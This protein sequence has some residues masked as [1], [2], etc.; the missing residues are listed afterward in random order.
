MPRKLVW[1]DRKYM[2]GWGCSECAWV[3]NPS[4]AP[5]GKSLDEVIEVYKQQRDA[6]F[7]SH[8]CADHPTPA[9]IRR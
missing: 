3:F 9:R 4:G 2:G 6:E 1:I 8:V 7:T 5:T